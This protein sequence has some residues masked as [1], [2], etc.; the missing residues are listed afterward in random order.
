MAIF[1]EEIDSFFI[2]TGHSPRLSA[3]MI[4]PSVS[5]F[6]PGDV[7]VF[8]Y[9][10][11]LFNQALVLVVSTKRG[12]GH[13]TS[14]KGN[15]LVSCYKLNGILPETTAIILSQLYNN[16]TKSDYSNITRSLD[17]LLGKENFRTY[18]ISKMRHIHK[19]I[20]NR[21]SLRNATS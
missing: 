4:P 16:R 5:F 8:R 7:L 11:I 1:S 2:E 19:A 13:F 6:S 18:N 17:A 20:L 10:P 12:R 14:G 3:K 15:L 9:S 21:E